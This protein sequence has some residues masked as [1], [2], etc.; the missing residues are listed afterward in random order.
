[1]ASYKLNIATV[2]GCPPVKELAKAL[3]DYGLPDDEEFGVLNCSATPES[4]FGTIVRKV[5]QSVQS[6]DAEAREVTASSVE[7]VQV[8]PFGCRPAGKALEL[9]AGSM[10]GIEQMGAFIGSNLGFATV[11]EPIELDIVAALDK[12]AKN[13]ERYQLRSVRVSDYAHNSFVSG[14]YAPKFLDSEHGQDFLEEHAEL[15]TAANV[16]FAGAMGRV[17]VRLSPTACFGYSCH[18]EDR[19]VVQS[20]LRKL[21]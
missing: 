16:R 15:L 1:M 13:T 6:L 10:S 14:P 9:Y 8:Y 11:V 18:E 3:E 5:Q 17:N 4:V 20:I 7:K 19:P 2:K 21:V 12:L